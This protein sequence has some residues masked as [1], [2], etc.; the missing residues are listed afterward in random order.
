MDLPHIEAIAFGP[1]L[2]PHGQRAR[3]TLLS[4]ALVVGAGA[5]AREEE[6]PYSRLRSRGGGWR[7]D[8]VLLEWEGEQGTWTL[9]VQDAAALATLHARAPQSLRAV[10]GTQVRGPRRGVPRSLVVASL[11]VAGV[12]TGMI[13]LL[14]TQSDRLVDLA[15][16]RIPP[17]WEETLGRATVESVV[18]AQEQRDAGAA[19]QVV[20]DLGARLAAQVQ[21]PY[22]FRWYL[23]EDPQVNAFAAPG[24][25]VVVFTGLLRAAES[26]EEL[27]GV[28]AHEVQHVVL[29][30][31]LRGM[32][33]GLGWRAVLAIVLGGAGHLGASVTSL[34]EHLGSLRFSRD[35]EREA[36]VQG[37]LL[38]Q[39]AGIDARGM[40]TF[41]EKLPSRGAPPEFLSTHPASDERAG[42]VR[43]MLGTAPR[44]APLPYDWRAVRAALETAAPAAPH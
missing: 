38:L 9:S 20:Q 33:R 37:V 19:A 3:V 29:R 8:M 39:R 34:V 23:V 6:V 43:E 16:E 36:D 10:L 4:R 14:A 2:P 7:G 25:H 1:G 31:S 13:L 5:L 11:L 18:Q 15:V 12:A 35:Q 30:H 41:F 21:S 32:V 26:P 17:E 42:M 40:V 24:G 27:A 44:A 28:L 22:K